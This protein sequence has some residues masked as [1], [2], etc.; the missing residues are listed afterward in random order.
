MMLRRAPH[1][2]VLSLLVLSCL[3]AG[4]TIKATLDSTSDTISNF[5]SSTSGHAWLT[6]DGLV[7]EDMK[8]DVFVAAN[9]ANLQQN[10]AQSDGEY[11]SAFESLLAVPHSER[12]PFRQTAQQHLDLLNGPGPNLAR[13]TEIMSASAQS[14]PP[15]VRR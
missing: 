8:T 13:F 9:W 1:V 11:L 7:R 5:L 3:S 2:T 4:C 10:I 15:E 6:E 14:L 12:A